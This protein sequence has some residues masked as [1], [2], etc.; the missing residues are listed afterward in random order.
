MKNTTVVTLQAPEL[1]KTIT[2]RYVD[3]GLKFG[4][5]SNVNLKGDF[6][7]WNNNILN[8]SKIEPYDHADMP[9]INNHKELKQIWNS[10]CG[11]IG[12]RS[13]LRVYIN[14]YTYGTD[15]YAHYDDSWI[16]KKFGDDSMSETAILYLNESWDIDWAGET[17]I[18][19]DNREIESSI[20][21]KFGRLLVFD[22]NK[23]HA[24]RPLSRMCPTLRT[25]LVF[26]T[27]DPNFNSELV[28]FIKELA[29]NIP[30]SKRTFFEH[31]FNTMLR[32]EVLKGS[33]D[34]CRAGLFHSV[35]G[36]EFFNYNNSSQISREVVRGM[37]GEYSEKLAYEFC[38]LRDR[39]NKIINNEP[40]YDERMHK[41]LMLMELANLSDQNGSGTYSE[42]INFLDQKIKNAGLV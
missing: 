1:L 17:V 6:G 14:G 3:N 40:S 37:I 12:Q 30:H 24:A 13:L 15:A 10:I 28:E 39:Y 29:V 7:H 22:S 19:D 20:L 5:K 32:L 9:Y 16:K 4:W 8:N 2:R 36:T 35:Y 33:E 26:K 27:L 23:L 41:D 18:Y 31:L 25:V 21:P 11:V 38:T 34:V 42:K